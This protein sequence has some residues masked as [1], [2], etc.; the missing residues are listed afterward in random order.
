MKKNNLKLALIGGF[1]LYLLSTGISYAA[2]HYFNGS[3][4]T[5]PTGSTQEKKSGFKVDNSAPKT[6]SCPINGEMYS[7]AEKD[8]WV[9]RRPIVAMIENS[10]DARPQSG[11]SSADVTYEAVAEGGITR[12]MN[13]FFCGA[14]GEDVKIAPVRSSRIYFIDWASEYGDLPLYVHVGGANDYAH[15]GDTAPKVR[16]LE[17]LEKIGWRVRGGNDLDTTFDGQFPVFYRDYE[18]LGHEVA[19]EHTMVSSTGKIW[20][21]AV[22]RGLEAT[23]KDG[24][25]WDQTF[26]SWKFKNDEAANKRG[27]TNEIKV[28]FWSGKSDYDVTWKY[29]TANNQYLRFN[30][31]VEH[32]DLNND[33]QLTAKNVVV[34]YMKE[35]DSIDKNLHTFIYTTGTGKAVIFQDGKA[36]SATW[37]KKDRTSRTIYTDSAGKEISFNRGKI[38]IETVPVGQNA[39]Y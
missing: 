18:R 12:T 34:Q 11:L 33:Q 14:A 21:E 32:K 3:G 26:V 29:D 5:N 2:F 24:K 37:S 36:I 7:K 15:S 4:V 19:T 16:A 8:L 39:V 25:K 9:K 30:G 31:G 17:L 13:V 20:E 28:T 35:E 27:T 1:V 22:K 38:W 23:A 10:V 6:E